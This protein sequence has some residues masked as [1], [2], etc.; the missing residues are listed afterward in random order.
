MTGFLVRNVR[1]TLRIRLPHPTFFAVG[2]LLPIL[3]HP[4]VIELH[5][6]LHWFFGDLPEPLT[7]VL[8]RLSDHSIPL[9][10]AILA[11]AVVPAL[12]EEIAFRGFIMSGLSSRGRTLQAI[13][14]SSIAFGIMH[15]IP[16]QVANA[17]LVGLVL[18]ALAF[19][20]QSIFPCI[21]FHFVNNALAVLHG[22]YGGRLAQ[23]GWSSLFF[24]VEES[25]LRY[26]WPT[27]LIC[28]G[29][30]TVI[31]VWLFR[32]LLKQTPPSRTGESIS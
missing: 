25:S 23:H 12:C 10:W 32:P 16:Q 19:R 15:M 1:E 24:A 28:A 30:A 29:L 20:S 17:A 7:E 6:R 4:L 21:A 11:V 9:G 13:I 22:R 27:L 2:C 31:I 8:K 14:L 18:G 3:M 26:K 5:A